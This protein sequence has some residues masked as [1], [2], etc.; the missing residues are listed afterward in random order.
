[1]RENYKKKEGRADEENSYKYKY[2]DIHKLTFKPKQK[3]RR[4]L[5]I[6]KKKKV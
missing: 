5:Y 3:R 1:M 6:S 4:K 2:I